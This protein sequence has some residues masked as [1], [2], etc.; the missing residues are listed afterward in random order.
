MKGSLPGGS[1]SPGLEPGPDPIDKRCVANPPEVFPDPVTN[2]PEN[3]AL[4]PAWEKSQVRHQ[5]HMDDH[6]GLAR[7]R[8]GRSSLGLESGQVLRTDPGV[9]AALGLPLRRSRDADEPSLNA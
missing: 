6:R 7:V 9:L 8:A 3:T 2:L 1:S 5:R 4:D